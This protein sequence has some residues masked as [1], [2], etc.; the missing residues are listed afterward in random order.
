[1][2]PGFSEDGEGVLWYK[3]RICVPNV[4]ELKEKILR[5][6]HESAYSI[7][8]RGNKMSMISRPLIAG[9]VWKETLLSMLP[10]VTLVSESKPS[11][12]D[13]LDDCSRCKCPSGSGKRLPQTLSWV[14]QE[15]SRAMI[16]FGWSWIDWLRLLTLYLSRPPLWAATSRVVYVK[17]SLFAW[18]AEENCVWHRDIIYFEVLGEVAWNLG[19]PI[20]LQFCLSPSDRWSDWKS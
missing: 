7:H 3:G 16:P 10:F 20:V 14:C 12:N 8:H 11:I 9:M 19:Y 15:L 13:L 17:D 18:S 1:M 4:M 5:E 2:L 6:A